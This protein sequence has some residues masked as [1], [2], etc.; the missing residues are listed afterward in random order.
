MTH[1]QPFLQDGVDVLVARH[2]SFPTALAPKDFASVTTSRSAS[3]VLSVGQAE[4][5]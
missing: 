1:P 2:L 5:S 4:D 3:V